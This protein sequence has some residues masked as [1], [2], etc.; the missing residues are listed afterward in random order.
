MESSYF[1]GRGAQIN[2]LNPY[3]EYEY[4]QEHIEGLDEELIPESPDRILFIDTPKNI[5]NKVDSPDIKLDYSINPYQGCEHGC[6]YCYAR[7]VHN[8]WGFSAGLDFESRIIVKPDAPKIL[9][10]SFLKPSYKPHAIMLSGNTDCYQ[11]IERKLQIT[12]KL[13]QVFAKYRHPVGIITK[14]SLIRRDID[15][16]KDLAKD[17]LLNVFISITS[18]NEK[19]KLLLEPRTTSYAKRFQ[20]VEELNQAGIPTGV[21]AAPIIPGL[22]DQEIPE[23]IKKASQ[24]GAKTIS[25][26]VV[27]LNGAVAEIFKDWVFK[28][29]PDRANKIW[30]QISELHAG[31]VNDS[32]FGRRMRGEGQWADTI[33]QLFR[34]NKSRYFKDR[35]MPKLTTT[36]FRKAGHYSLFS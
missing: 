3:C 33:S 4:V 2:T 31:R 1:K 17:H 7:N 30:K 29:F 24:A 32:Q 19:L 34:I 11:P 21:M 28:T 5:I 20:T 16:L 26:T 36:L 6:I 14:N 8:Y 12:R 35:S 13:L 22:N 27:R 15:I 9:E 23:L 25:Y 10:A 18:L